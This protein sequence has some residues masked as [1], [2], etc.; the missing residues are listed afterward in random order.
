MPTMEKETNISCIIHDDC[1]LPCSFNPPGTVVIHWYKQQ[2]PVHSYYYNKDQFG[3]QNKH[4]SG[5]T[6]LFHSHIP[7]GNASLL[8]RRVKVQD[9]GRYKCYTSTRKGNQE[10]FVNLEVKALIHT[11][12][13]ELSDEMVTC[14][15]NNIYPAPLVTWATVPPS[16][17]ETF[18]NVTTKTTDHKGLFNVQSSVKIQGNVSEYTYLCSFVS[19]DKTQVWTAS[20]KNQ[21]M[22]KEEGGTLCIPCI[23]PHGL[24]NF[25]LTWT[26]TSSSEPTVIVR[27]DSRHGGHTFNLWEGLAELDE[28]RLQLGNGSL[29]LHKP[30]SEA[31]SGTY[32]CI[33]TGHQ[34]RLIVQTNVNI[35][36]ASMGLT[37]RSMQR[38]RW[39]AAAS[40]AF[41]LFTIIL[42]IPQCLR[43][44]GVQ[45]T[46]HR[47]NGA[48]LIEAG[49]H[50]DPNHTA[51]YIIR[52]HAVD[53]RGLH[54]QTRPREEL[55]GR[56]VTENYHSED[57][58]PEGKEGGKTEERKNACQQ[59]SSVELVKFVNTEPVNFAAEENNTSDSK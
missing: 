49:L 51:T 42:A 2:I 58:T 56:N 18:E 46:T 22:T 14:S 12:I 57:S 43:H 20:R 4:F 33:F 40:A 25:T 53:C 54:Q 31:H 9:K 50:K 3:L 27:Y 5:R 19:A 59:S 23:L 55:P 45:S 6:C 11:V 26:F 44:R 15:S 28:E 30:D 1:I 37:E 8:L 48:G 24:P 13:M 39:S 35:T 38:S 41:V 16:T 52:Q 47:H 29:L 21:V 36:V 17:Q 32:A 7:Q 10:I 34:S